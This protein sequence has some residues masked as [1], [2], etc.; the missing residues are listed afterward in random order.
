[1]KEALKR[2]SELVKSTNVCEGWNSEMILIWMGRY[3]LLLSKVVMVTHCII[4][5]EYHE[6]Q[7]HPVT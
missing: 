2:W 1:M 4:C 7:V 5:Y 6:I 3:Y